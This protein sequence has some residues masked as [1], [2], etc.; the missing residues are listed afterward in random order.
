MQKKV[1]IVLV[2]ILLVFLGIS[3][4]FLVYN[5]ELK[6]TLEK[7]PCS[8]DIERK[9][10]LE[11]RKLRKTLKKDLEEKRRADRISQQVMTMRLEAEKKRQTELEEKIERLEKGAE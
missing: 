9:I 10:S 11:G 5:L 2:L 8:D 7:M 4:Y 1:V 3:I 6:K